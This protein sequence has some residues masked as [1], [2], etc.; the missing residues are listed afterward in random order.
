MRKPKV[1]MLVQDDKVQFRFQGVMPCRFS[2]YL[3]YYRTRFPR[4][5]WKPQAKYWELPKDDFQS[6]YEASRHVFGASNVSINWPNYSRKIAPIQ[7]SLFGNSK[8]E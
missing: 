2:L 4:M 7:L 3:N 5:I 1:I 6:V 8:E